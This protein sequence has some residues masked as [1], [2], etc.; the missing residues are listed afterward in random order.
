MSAPPT[1]PALP[2]RS[3]PRGTEPLVRLFDM[4]PDPRLPSR[5]GLSGELAERYDGDL[6]IALRPDRPTVIANFVETLDGVVAMDARGATGGGQ[7][8][9]FSPTDRF[10]MGLLR[11]LADVVLVG[12]STIRSS[13]RVT[14]TPGGI[15]P[16]AER[17]YLE[18]RA[19]LGLA[20][21]PTTLIATSSG[22]LDP[23]MPV[24]MEV[25]APIVIAAPTPAAERLRA[26]AFGSNVSIEAVGAEG[27]AALR[28]T[29]GL[30]RRLGARVVLSEAGPHLFASLAAAN[31]VDELF[32]T[33]A[34]Q[35]AGRADGTGRLAMVEGASLWPADPRWA[36]LWSVRRAGDHL[37][38]RY[39]FEETR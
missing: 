36:R 12:A 2:A 3:E 33:L 27:L 16:D 9:G 18:L 15:F 31:L 23:G 26:Q 11:A 32:V 17:A 34:P 4:P 35:L 22:G 20:P 13:G 24:F 29:L 37:F 21:A 39:L 6:R 38:Q 7:V 28:S 10:V 5:G 19:E 1:A 14:W 8:S 30:A 25:T